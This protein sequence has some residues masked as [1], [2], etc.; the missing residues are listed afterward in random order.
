[1]NRLFIVEITPNY[2]DNN[3]LFSLLCKA[4]RASLMLSY[5]IRKDS[6]ICFFI[7]SLQVS[8]LCQGNMVKGLY[9]DEPSCIGI[10]KK[11]FSTSKKYVLGFKLVDNCI[12]Y[13]NLLGLHPIELNLVFYNDI[14]K[15]RKYI[16]NKE[17]G[18]YIKI[19]SN[20]Y[21]DTDIGLKLWNVI[22]IINIALDNIFQYKIN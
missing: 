14:D 1:M 3:T 18:V 4:I 10:L 2:I 8:L 9:A 20:E 15:L 6:S 11:F 5:N 19:A 22:S 16:A 7:K 17:N 21:G 13:A 12:N